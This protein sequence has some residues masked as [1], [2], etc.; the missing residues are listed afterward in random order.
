[1]D[2]GVVP[3]DRRWQMALELPRPP[4]EQRRRYRDFRTYRGRMT[5]VSSW[6]RH[7]LNWMLSQY[8]TTV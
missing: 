1:M 5:T 8:I 2:A 7:G 4:H 6:C 3:I